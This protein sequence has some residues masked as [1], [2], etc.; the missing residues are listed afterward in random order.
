MRRV[1]EQSG[2]VSE[3]TKVKIDKSQELTKL[4]GRRLREACAS[5]DAEAIPPAIAS[6]IAK[7]RCAEATLG[8]A[9]AAATPG[10]ETQRHDGASLHRHRNCSKS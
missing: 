6:G 5:W 2:M 8:A 3:N 9:D 10:N 1:E 7:I 4:I